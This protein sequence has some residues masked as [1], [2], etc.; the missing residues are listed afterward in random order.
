MT[1]RGEI[2]PAVGAS[3]SDLMP[4]VLAALDRVA[5]TQEPEHL[6]VYI[7][8]LPWWLNVRLR[9]LGFKVY[10]PSW[11]ML[12]TA[13]GARPLHADAPPAPSLARGNPP[14]RC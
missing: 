14:V 4:V 9:P 8:T 5:M 1:Y 7:A 11:V 3:Q 12:G 2:G 10:W 6:S 13:A